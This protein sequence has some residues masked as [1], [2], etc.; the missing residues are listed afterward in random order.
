LTD[1]LTNQ[2]APTVATDPH[3]AA[4]K[5][6]H[7]ETIETY[8]EQ[9][10]FDYRVVWQDRT[11]RALHFGVWYPE[12]R[13]HAESLL[14]M[15]REVASTLEI[16]PGMRVLDAGCGIGGSSL[17][18]AEN[19]DVSVVGITVCEKQLA[20]ARRFAR[21]RGV[22]DRVTFE[23]A[24]YTDTNL[25]AE[26]FDVVWAQE[27]VCY[28]LDKRDFLAEA[29]RLLRPGGQIVVEDWF[30]VA[31]NLPAR[32]ER[33]LLEWLRCWAIA[34]VCTG[35]E[36]LDAGR[37]VGFTDVSLRDMTL[38]VRP[39]LARLHRIGVATFPFWAVVH[40]LGLRSTV[41]HDNLRGAILQWRALNDRLWY[42]AIFS[43]RKP[44]GA[45]SPA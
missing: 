4:D 45:P 25:E 28:A 18:L 22:A 14:N 7:L 9:S 43:A 16:K 3:R 20:M 29:Y 27:S 34:D 32:K 40:R 41:A 33:L 39:S 8:Y 13:S 26:S 35:D 21:E 30:R 11:N 24:D 12:T 10:W 17:W 19:F 36:F 37:S 15:N 2:A 31:R 5:R 38:Y 42:D 1:T 23:L 6:A 44:D